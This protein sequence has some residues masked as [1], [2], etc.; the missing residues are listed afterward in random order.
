MIFPALEIRQ[1]HILPGSRARSHLLP[2]ALPPLGRAQHLLQALGA[3]IVRPLRDDDEQP[4]AAVLVGIAIE[5]DIEP[6]IARI[7]DQAQHPRRSAR[8]GG[9]LVKMR[10]V[11]RNPT[12]L[13]DLQGLFEWIE[14]A[15]SQR[16]EEHTSEL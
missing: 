9:A 13:A 14:E 10:N 11:D 8:A 7:L 5:G 2:D 3:T 16:S 1:P 4:S 12:L 15:I 6:T